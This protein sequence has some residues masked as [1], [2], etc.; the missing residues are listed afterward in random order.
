MC[1]QFLAEQTSQK[2]SERED[3]AAR[4]QQFDFPACLLRRHV[5]RCAHHAPVP[6]GYRNH[7][8]RN[9]RAVFAIRRAVHDYSV[10]LKRVGLDGIHQDFREPPVH[11][12]N[13]AERADHHIGRLE[14]AVEDSSSVCESNRI[15]DAQ[16]DTQAIRS[17]SQR[18]DVL[19]E[20]L[21]FD[22]FH[23]VKNA[24]ILKCA[25]IVHRNDSRMLEPGQHARLAH[26]AICE[27]AFGARYFEH[28]QRDA[29]LQALVF[30]C[31]D[32]AHP[33]TRHL[34]DE[35]VARAAK[36]RKLDAAAQVC[37][38]LVGKMPHGV[39]G[40]VIIELFI[41]FLRA[42]A[43]RPH[44]ASQPNTVFV[45]RWNS[46]SLPQISRKRSSAILRN[47]RRAQASALVTSVTAIPY[48]CAS[49]LYEML[50]S[51]SRSYASKSWKA[52]SRSRSEQSARKSSTASENRLRTHS[53]SKN[54]SSD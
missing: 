50:S 26:E 36:V 48:C 1:R 15:A 38:H 32:A 44:R 53:F 51:P 30:R 45:S 43:S 18:L 41:R 42:D 31:V 25:G 29:A 24:A 4:I 13:L 16:K 9:R 37:K 47:S 22:E 21:P 33:S 2:C 27:V 35:A 17:G 20:P 7:G 39:V 10:A 40:D 11:H 49:C 34:R 52:L 54:S 23:G 46:S 19:I 6:R 5:P 3:I 12:Q 8:C 14:I 28:F